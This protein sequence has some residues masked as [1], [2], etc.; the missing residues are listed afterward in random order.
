M[1]S[2]VKS[3]KNGEREDMANKP[4][5]YVTKQLTQHQNFNTPYKSIDCVNC[6]NRHKCNNC[7][8]YYSIHIWQSDYVYKEIIIETSDKKE[9]EKIVDKYDKEN[10]VDFFNIYIGIENG[11]YCYLKNIGPQPE[12]ILTNVKIR[13]KKELNDII[14]R[15]RLK[16]YMTTD[17]D[18]DQRKM[19]INLLENLFYNKRLIYTTIPID[20]KR[21]SLKTVFVTNREEFNKAL[22]QNNNRRWGVFKRYAKNATSY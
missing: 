10:S 22:D 7:E 1:E 19:A 5:I 16:F 9:M 6:N 15:Y 20:N 4:S 21:D 12:Y 14:N 18:K 17:L 3:I 8:E 2:I 11:I 13:N